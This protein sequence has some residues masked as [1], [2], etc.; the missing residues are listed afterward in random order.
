M[1]DKHYR[2]PGANRKSGSGLGLYI[3][4]GIARLLGVAMAHEVVE[5]KARFNLRP[6]C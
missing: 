2:G 4:Q 3:V 1:F 5:G 6:P